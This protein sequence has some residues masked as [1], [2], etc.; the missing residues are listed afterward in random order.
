MKGELHG[1]QKS[2]TNQS[3][4]TWGLLDSPTTSQKAHHHHQCS[5]SYQDVYTYTHKYTEA[6]LVYCSHNPKLYLNFAQGIMDNI[7]V[8]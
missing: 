2:G 7:P 3:Q 6:Y 4:H 1:E 8:Q 5:S